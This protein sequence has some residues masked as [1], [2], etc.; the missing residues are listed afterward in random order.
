MCRHVRAVF[1]DKIPAAC[2]ISALRAAE[3]PGARDTPDCAHT[4]A[5]ENVVCLIDVYIPIISPNFLCTL[6]ICIHAY[7]RDEICAMHVRSIYVS[8]AAAKVAAR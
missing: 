7:T 8:P 6:L 4:S 5:H 2:L 3:R 1:G